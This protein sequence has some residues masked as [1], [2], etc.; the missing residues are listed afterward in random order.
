VTIRRALWGAF[1]G[2]VGW[3]GCQDD[4]WV[5]R[6][7]D[8]SPAGD[9]AR[10]DR[11]AP[12]D[13]EDAVAAIDGADGAAIDLPPAPDRP[14]DTVAADASVPDAS[15]PDASVPGGLTL[16]GAGFVST[17]A[18]AP[19]VGA[20]RLSETGFEFG[21]RACVGSLCQIGGLVP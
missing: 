10:G 18:S 14:D 17:G 3:M 9:S 13:A 8:A 11:P 6:P 7:L 5:Y 20:L 12:E 1:A 2:L 15:V 19:A 4:P 16:R 21:E